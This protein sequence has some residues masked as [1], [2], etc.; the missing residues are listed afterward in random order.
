MGSY[1]AFVRERPLDDVHRRYHDR[2]YGFPIAS[3]DE[4]FERLILEINQ[5]GLS[6]ETILKKQEHFRRA[7]SGLCLQPFTACPPC[8]LPPPL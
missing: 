1:C 4:L 2:D 5:A 3:D 6:W 8:R 7:Y